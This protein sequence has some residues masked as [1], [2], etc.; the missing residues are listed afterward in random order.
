MDRDRMRAKGG[1]GSRLHR[2]HRR[3]RAQG[4]DDCQGPG[5]WSLFFLQSI[6][7]EPTSLFCQA[8]FGITLDP[9]TIAFVT[10]KKRH[11]VEDSTWPRFTLLGQSIGSIFLALE[12]LQSGMIPDVWIGTCSPTIALKQR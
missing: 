11:L 9:A 12:A 4:R 3:R 8:R 1:A 7:G 5:A 10:L 2:V 6:S